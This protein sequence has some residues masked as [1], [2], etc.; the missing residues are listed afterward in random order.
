MREAENRPRQSLYKNH[1]RKE[2]SKDTKR[3]DGRYGKKQ[4]HLQ[5]CTHKTFRSHR[6]TAPLQWTPGTTSPAAQPWTLHHICARDRVQRAPEPAH[7]GDSA[8]SNRDLDSGILQDEDRFQTCAGVRVL[9]PLLPPPP[10]GDLLAPTSWRVQPDTSPK[11]QD[12][13][14]HRQ[15]QK[16]T[17]PMSPAGENQGHVATNR[18]ANAGLDPGPG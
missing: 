11:P 18:N 16:G 15:E 4:D 1:Y 17:E 9:S 13:S 2:P 14:K 10:P 6:E 8:S 3:S 5:A 12:A 7:P